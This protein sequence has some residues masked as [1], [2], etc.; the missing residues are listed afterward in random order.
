LLVVKAIF[1]SNLNRY[2]SQ[3]FGILR[4]RPGQASLDDVSWVPE[5]ILGRHNIEMQQSEFINPVLNALQPLA[6]P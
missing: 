1:S 6:C 4:S 3:G 2:I 5:R